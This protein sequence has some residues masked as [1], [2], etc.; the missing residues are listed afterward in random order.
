MRKGIVFLISMFLF[1]QSSFGVG[2]TFQVDMANQSV[3]PIGVHL[4][5]NFTDPNN[6]GIVDNNLPNWNPGGIALTNTIAAVW[7]IT[8][9]LAPGLYEYKFV[10]GNDWSN[11]E[12]FSAESSCAQWLNGNRF[13]EV[14]GFDIVLPMVC[15]N[16][17]VACGLGCMEMAACNYD[18]NATVEGPCNYP[19]FI[20]EIV[21]DQPSFG[22]FS[23]G[24]KLYPNGGYYSQI[25]WGTSFGSITS[26]SDTLLIN[27]NIAQDFYFIGTDTNGCVINIGP[28]SVQVNS[29]VPVSI[30]LVSADST[31]NKNRISWDPIPNEA[32]QSIVVFKETNIQDV[33]EAIGEVEYTANGVFEDV[34]SNPNVQSNRYKIG[35]RDS[36]GFLFESADGVHKS[37]HLTAG[38]GLGSAVNL[39]W[40][41]YEGISMDGYNLYRGSSLSNMQVI[42]SVANNVLSYSDINPPMSE[43][44][45]MIELVGASCS[46]DGS[47]MK[48][49][50]NVFNTLTQSIEESIVKPCWVYPNPSDSKITIEVAAK[51]IHSEVYIYDATGNIVKRDLMTN[52]RQSIN[53]NELEDGFYFLKIDNYVSRLQLVH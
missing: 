48:A 49:R 37:V 6:D 23:N 47:L 5:G 3:S 22:C 43:V 26:V 17:C 46:A 39:I 9:D 25:G 38:V 34:N 52:S 18:V 19:D 32:V 14:G 8:L 30:C 44:Y 11:P 24:V 2:V 10:N 42:A 13:I 15:W 45:Y 20:P 36:C 31:S 1:H 21:I 35:M 29:P 16:E 27:G 40:N 53:L 12:F 28:L 4:A 51:Y 33:F 50:S 7:T 41:S